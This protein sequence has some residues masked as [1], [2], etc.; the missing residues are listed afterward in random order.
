M[1]WVA[2]FMVC[3][4]AARL[5]ANAG[6]AEASS[7]NVETNLRTRDIR[8]LRTCGPR[9]RTP[10]ASL[11]PIYLWPVAG[12]SHDHHLHRGGFRLEPSL[13]A[14]PRE[15]RAYWQRAPT[16]RPRHDKG[17]RAARSTARLEP[18]YRPA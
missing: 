4:T 5:W 12:R 7:R 14:A 18:D 3:S 1:K 17:K 11:R 8:T 15:A 6:G 13:R 9:R 16:G 2:R 10:P